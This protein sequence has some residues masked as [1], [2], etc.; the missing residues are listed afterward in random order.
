VFLEH[1]EWRLVVMLSEGLLKMSSCLRAFFVVGCGVLIFSML[2][3]GN[4]SETPPLATHVY[5]AGFQLNDADAEVATL[6]SDGQAVVLG[7]G[8]NSSYATSIAVSGTDV[9]AA[10]VE[11]NGTNDV[12]KYWKNGIPVDLTDGTQRGFANSVVVAEPNVYVAGGEQTSNNTVAKYWKNGAGVVLA[13]LGQGALAHSI[14]VSG[15]DVYAAGWQGKTTQLDPTHTL[16]TQVATYWKNGVPIE[17]TDATALSI[18]YSIFVTGADVYVAGFACQTL[19]PNCAIATYWKNGVQVQL[20]NLTGSTISSIFVSGTNVY[21]SGNQDNDL[22]QLWKNEA[23][24]QLT[25]ASLSSAANQVFVSGSDVFVGGASLSNS[26]VPTAT[27][28]K[29]GIPT[30]VG[31]GTHFSTAL[32]L[33]LVNR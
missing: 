33:T 9:Y 15:K 8:T 23:P 6:W 1:N 5:A 32:A 27:Y 28:W 16:H 7:A 13:D 2:G 21:A 26:G 3:C 20:T 14:F 12:A 19:A 17:L 31:D 30:K 29:N 18:A 25:G 4:G 11:G 10:G 24:L 22:A